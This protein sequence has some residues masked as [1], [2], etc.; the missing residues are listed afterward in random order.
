M[1]ESVYLIIIY[2]NII[3]KVLSKSGNVF[4]FS[5]TQNLIYYQLEEQYDIHLICSQ[6]NI[7]LI[8]QEYVGYTIS[9]S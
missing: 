8:Y 4:F 6:S 7:I 3:K 9:I 1:L 5:S 2:Y